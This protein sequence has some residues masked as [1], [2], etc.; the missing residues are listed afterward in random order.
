[1]LSTKITLNG[2]EIQESKPPGNNVHRGTF[3]HSGT[4]DQSNFQNWEFGKLN[5]IFGTDSQP[6]TC[7][8]NQQGKAVC[9]G[10]KSNMSL[11]NHQAVVRLDNERLI[12]AGGVNYL[13]NH[14]TSKTYEYNIRTSKYT[15]MP[16]LMNRRFFAQIVFA[17][18]R[19]LVVGGRDYGNDSVAIMRSC[20]EFNFGNQKWEEVGNLNYARCNFTSIVFHNDIYVFS[21][22]SKTSN[23]LNSIEKFNFKKSSWEVMGLQVKQDM[24]GNLSLHKGHEIIVF[25][26]TRAWGAGALI[27][28]NM[29]YGADLGDAVYQRMSCKNALAKPIVL[30]KHV[31]V[32][33]GF[34]PNAIVVNKANLKIVDDSKV[35]GM[36]KEVLS[37][38][39]RLSIQTFRLTKCSYI[40]PAE[41]MGGRL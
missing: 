25:G 38:V 20:E 5:M 10:M 14:V 12:F 36:Y 41:N 2:N 8:V 15:K 7:F 4:L 40:L 16:T 6:F 28:L 27:R 3:A 13:F 21:G 30:D 11:K 19:L 31:I 35:T 29:K 1:L 9:M 32:L 18:G 26:G 23:L 24:L 37:Q 33:G 22:L 17:R 39:D 34:F